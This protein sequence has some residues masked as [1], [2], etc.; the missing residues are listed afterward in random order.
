MTAV[1]NIQHEF[2]AA[3][4]QYNDIDEVFLPTVGENGGEADTKGL[5]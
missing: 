1:F 4:I 3:L 5:D 2:T